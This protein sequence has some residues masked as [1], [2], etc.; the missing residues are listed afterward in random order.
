[1]YQLMVSFRILKTL[2]ARVL[3]CFSRVRLFATLWIVAP[4]APLSMGFPWQEYW[5]GLPRPPPGDLLEPGIPT[6]IS[7]LSCIGRWVLYHQHRHLRVPSLLSSVYTP[8]HTH[9]HPQLGLTFSSLKVLF[10]LI[11][12]DIY[13]L[14][15]LSYILLF[16][17]L[18]LN[19]YFSFISMSS[20][21]Q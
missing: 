21:L 11:F 9:T 20:L 10:N 8:M 1:M 3:S 14:H 18:L 12:T 2:H 6:L 13:I 5:S 16:G 7:Y 4:Q 15:L 19:V 17:F